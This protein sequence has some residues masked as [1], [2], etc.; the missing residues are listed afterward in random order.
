MAHTDKSTVLAFAI[1]DKIIANKLSVGLEEGDFVAYGDHNNVPT[2]RAVTVAAGTKHRELAGVAGPGGRTKNTLEVVVTVYYS[3][4]EA[5][6]TARLAVDQIAENVEFL[7]HTDTTVGGIIIHGFVQD[8]VPGI[9]VR[10]TS[11]FRVV[12]LHFVGQTK[13]NVTA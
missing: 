12:Q 1:R 9:I 3:V 10:E 13:T 7:L 11:M 5:E 8:W 2:G 6:E 4:L